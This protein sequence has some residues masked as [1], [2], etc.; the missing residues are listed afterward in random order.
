MATDDNWQFKRISITNLHLDSRNPRLG[1]GASASSPRELIQHLF[2]HDKAMEVAE[3]I[4]IRGFFPN[5]P[6]LAIRENGRYVV[7]EGNRRLAALKALRDPSLL[8]ARQQRTLERLRRRANN[9]IATAVPVTIAPNRR[10]TDQQLAGRHVGTPVLPWQAENR[11]N[12]ILEKLEEGYEP[13][14]VAAELGFSSADIQ[15]AKQ[16]RAVAEMAR[17]LDV[18]TDVRQKLDHPRAAVLSTIRRVLDSSVGR[19][20][21]KVQPDGEHGFRGLT[22]K[23]S[24]VR[25]FVKLVTDI[26]KGGESSRTLNTNEEIRR[27]FEGWDRADL[28]T[29]RGSFVPSDIYGT[30][31]APAPEQGEP[32][33]PNTLPA[34]Q[35]K[36]VLP[37]DFKVRVSNARLLDIHRELTRLKRDEFPNAGAVL[38][39]VFFEL[40]TVD[41]LKRTDRLEE[42]VRRL[43]GRGKLQ[44]DIPS[45][46]QLAPEITEIAKANLSR[47]EAN[48]VEKAIKHDPAAPFTVSDLHSFVHQETSLPTDRDILQ[49]WLRVEPLMRLMVENVTKS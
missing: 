11:A 5:E 47:T 2:E 6:L 37:R 28:P 26:V 24:F 22:S 16:I 36:T 14:D 30:S 23:E 9:T 39:R 27:Y 19:D 48:Q 32:Q 1:R 31:G 42:I 43:G 12:F 25:A 33:R 13:E 45:M 46:R 29:K 8:E 17:S 3:S 15:E 34:R 4:A 21:L 38:L 44:Y 20:F 18:E 10:A 40:A 41:Y 35:S 7:V 49:F